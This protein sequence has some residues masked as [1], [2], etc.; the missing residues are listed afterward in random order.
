MKEHSSSENPPTGSDSGTCGADGGE[1]LLLPMQA[2]TGGVQRGLILVVECTDRLVCRVE[3]K[4]SSSVRGRQ[5]GKSGT[6]SDTAV[7]REY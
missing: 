6:V 3:E 1:L 5:A 4:L 2:T 7:S